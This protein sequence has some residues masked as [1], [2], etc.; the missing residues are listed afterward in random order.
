MRKCT[1]SLFKDQMTWTSIEIKVVVRR[2]TKRSNQ[3][4]LPFDISDVASR[5]FSVDTYYNLELSLHGIKLMC[6]SILT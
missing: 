6:P 5:N 1:T 2:R 4:F 3:F